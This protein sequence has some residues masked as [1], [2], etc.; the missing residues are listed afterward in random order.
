MP[1]VIVS[2]TY[3]AEE[4]VYR[5]TFA[6]QRQHVFNEEVPNPD[7]NPDDEHSPPKLNKQTTVT[8]Q[9]DA[10]DIVWADDDPR[11]RNKTPDKIAKMQRADVKKMLDKR[12]A[13][14]EQQSV[15]P[16]P[17]TVADLG[18]AGEQL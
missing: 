15:P 12:V 8:V 10:E 9:E 6:K 17:A 14:E 18:G 13:D 1:Y 5:L 2:H 11:W 16:D 7:Y 3:Y 4:G